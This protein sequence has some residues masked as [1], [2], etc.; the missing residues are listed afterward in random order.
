MYNRGVQGRSLNLSQEKLELTVVV[1]GQPA[2]VSAE[3]HAPLFSIIPKALAQ[4]GNVG[5]PPEN[6]E[7]RDVAG[8]L[9]DVNRTIS[10]YGFTEETRL[11]LN[12]KAGIG[13]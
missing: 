9:L 13:G 8:T 5:Q 2:E 12:L 6:W 4:T 3:P 10:S 11:F 1:N 7:L